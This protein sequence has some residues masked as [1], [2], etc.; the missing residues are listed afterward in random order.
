MKY[1]IIIIL[2]LYGCAP[3]NQK[4]ICVLKP[5]WDQ[6]TLEQ[7]KNPSDCCRYKCVPTSDYNKWN[8]CRTKC[9][10]EKMFDDTQV[11]DDPW[12]KGITDL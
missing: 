5:Y 11:P 9:E 4:N 10:M 6:E 1:V 7:I 3:V 2:L 12:G 8:D